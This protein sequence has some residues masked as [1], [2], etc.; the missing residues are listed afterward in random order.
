MATHWIDW[1]QTPPDVCRLGVVSIGN[2]DG[3]HRGHGALLLQVVLQGRALPAPS[4]VVTFDPHPLE[5]LRPQAVP[6][7]LTTVEDRAE[8]LHAIGIEHVVILRVTP[9]LLAL[10]AETFFEAVVVRGL[11]T[12]A[13]VE[14][15]N[16]AFG[17]NR[18]GNMQRLAELCI[19][20]NVALTCVPRQD[21]DSEEISSSAIRTALQAGDVITAAHLL[22]RP[23]R[24]RGLVTSGAQRGRTLGFPTANLTAI[25]TLIP[26]DGVYAVQAW[27]DGQLWSGAANVGPNPTFDEAAR[28]V[29]VHLLDYTGDLY[30]THL[31][32]HFVAR[33]RDTRKFAGVEELLAQLRQDVEQV[34]TLIREGAPS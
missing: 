24:L 30:G 19:L 25:P 13:L 8:V 12:R 15:E 4:V 14:G 11:A 7:R 20:H 3:V 29:E 32:I 10:E 28:K 1:H 17:R 34:R 21:L 18:G 2:F 9:D 5:L 27:I 16:F 31:A 33:L 22:G 6:P 26:R 23:Y